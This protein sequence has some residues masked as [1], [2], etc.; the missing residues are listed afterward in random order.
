MFR[1]G[2]LTRSQDALIRVASSN[3]TTSE[4]LRWESECGVSAS[5][6]LDFLMSFK[7]V[8]SENSRL[9][10]SEAGSALI[11]EGDWKAVLRAQMLEIVGKSRPA[12]ASVLQRGREAAAKILPLNVLQCFEA[13]DLFSEA[14]IAIAKWWDSF[15]LAGIEQTDRQNIEIG[16]LG[17]SMSYRFEINRISKSP[18][19]VSL[20][21]PRSPF[22]LLSFTNTSYQSEL[23][24]EV[25]TSTQAWDSALALLSRAQWEHMTRYPRSVLHLWSVEGKRGVMSI[26]DS[27]VLASHIPS[28]RG[29]GQWEKT[30]IP[31]IALA[32]GP[33]HALE[34]IHGN[35]R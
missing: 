2:V 28:N 1:I 23:H 20:D 22:D 4:F 16:R 35:D 17:E 34:V 29:N 6:L 5:G 18:Q 27:N 10:V 11:Q 15:F 9:S 33:D 3:L 13:A 30:S 12:W 26:I 19:W 7:W 24:I 14:D 21:R 31:F 32:G 25:K 8:V